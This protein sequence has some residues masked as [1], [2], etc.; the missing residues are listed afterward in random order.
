MSLLLLEG[1]SSSEEL[2]S[3]VTSMLRSLSSY[4]GDRD[5]IDEASENPLETGDVDDMV[6]LSREPSKE[7][8]LA[9][10]VQNGERRF[11]KKAKKNKRPSEKQAPLRLIVQGP[12][13]PDFV[14]SRIEVFLEK[15]KSTLV[16]M[17]ESEFEEYK[18]PF[19]RK[20]EKVKCKNYRQEIESKRFSFDDSQLQVAESLQIRREDLLDFY[21]RTIVAGAERRKVSIWVLSAAEHKGPCVEGRSGTV[22]I[23]NLERFKDACIQKRNNPLNARRLQEPST[24]LLLSL[25]LQ[26]L[27]TPSSCHA[28][29]DSAKKDAKDEDATVSSSQAVQLFASARDSGAEVER[30]KPEERRSFASR[31]YRLG[32]LLS[33]MCVVPPQ[34][35]TL[36]LKLWEDGFSIDDG[37]LRRFD[38]PEN[39]EFVAEVR[40]GHIPK[41]LQLSHKGSRLDVRMM[42]MARRFADPKRRVSFVEEGD[43]HK[44]PKIAAFFGKGHLLGGP[45]GGDAPKPKKPKTRILS[46]QSVLIC[47]PSGRRVAT[48]FG[49][50][51]TVAD[52]RSYILK[53]DPML[54]NRPFRL[55]N[56][57]TRREIPIGESS[58]SSERLFKTLVIVRLDPK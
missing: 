7:D 38:A 27:L 28:R 19:R 57:A 40:R 8:M 17:S 50:S 48:E 35:V 32:G 26:R 2:Y 25:R 44:R 41:E 45:S 43:T 13:D 5:C 30:Q 51:E 29:I 47:L 34:Q 1:P 4:C 39:A 33:P 49:P 56:A 53:M 12:Y 37:P 36:T 23:E 54:E 24:S 15:F 21:E 16:E 52:L 6:S 31:G 3:P 42:C 58:L 22:E 11:L 18:E 20:T 46:G 10:R 14:E 9:N 55:I